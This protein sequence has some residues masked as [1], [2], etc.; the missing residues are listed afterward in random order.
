MINSQLNEA[1]VLQRQQDLL[2]TAAKVR[3]ARQLRNKRPH[4][5]RTR[6]GWWLVQVGIRMVVTDATATPLPTPPARP[7]RP[8]AAD[9]TVEPVMS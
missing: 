7:S 9:Q 2:A 4:R 6:A 5:L 8:Y 3:L 1:L